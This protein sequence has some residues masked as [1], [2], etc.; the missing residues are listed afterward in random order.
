MAFKIDFKSVLSQAADAMFAMG[1]MNTTTFHG[2]ARPV[3]LG[4][5]DGDVIKAQALALE[6]LATYLHVVKKH[7]DRFLKQFDEKVS[8][9]RILVSIA[10]KQTTPVGTACGLDPN[11]EGLERLS[12]LFGFQMPGPVTLEPKRLDAA[13]FQD[14]SRNDNLFV[15]PTFASNGLDRF[16]QNVKQYRDRGGKAVILPCIVGLPSD[17]GETENAHREMEEL[18]AALSP[19][20]DGFVWTPTLAHSR[21]LISRAEFARTARLFKRFAVDKLKLVEMPPYEQPERSRWLALI[22]AFLVEGGDGIVAVSG[23]EVPRSRVPKPDRWPYESAIMSGRALGPYRQRAIEDA[24]RAFPSAF[25]VACGGFHKRD[26]AFKACQFANVIA[27][28]EAFTR[29]GPG[30]ARTLLHKLA[31][32]LDYLRKK[33]TI[34]SAS[35]VPYQQQC[36]GRIDETANRNHATWTS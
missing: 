27:E 35:L 22:E 13:P 12:Y 34:D 29:F 1:L 2:A 10:G 6:G 18:L 31:Q 36:W 9:E 32:R 4:H 11:A 20:V 15:P 17:V 8:Y 19:Y 23:L 3:L 33:G 14:D 21:A 26:E 7:S 24:R 16:L 25:I 30:M 5:S 28:N